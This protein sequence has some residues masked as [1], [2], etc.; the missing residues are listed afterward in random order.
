MASIKTTE[1]IINQ[2]I[3]TQLTGS[4]LI[5]GH[6]EGHIETGIANEKCAT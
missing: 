5:E 1:Y 2:L 3:L 4:S 6:I